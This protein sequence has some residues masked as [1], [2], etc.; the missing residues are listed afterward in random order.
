MQ[1]STP[2]LTSSNPS[3]SSSPMGLGVEWAQWE[4]SCGSLT[5]LRLDVGWAAVLR[6]LDWAGRPGWSLGWGSQL[7]EGSAG[8]GL[9]HPHASVWPL[10]RLGVTVAGFKGAF[11]SIPRGPDG[12]SR[13]LMTEPPTSWR[14]TCCDPSAEEAADHPESGR[15]S[16]R[17]LRGRAAGP[18]A[19]EQRNG[20]FSTAVQGRHAVCTG[21]RRQEAGTCAKSED[22]DSPWAA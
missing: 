22:T 14:S 6:G 13:L 21:A 5:R 7:A 17:P 1:Q 19:E 9:E 10:P 4:L 18:T 12:H 2:R 8:A 3:V 11:L 15:G 16:R 20:G